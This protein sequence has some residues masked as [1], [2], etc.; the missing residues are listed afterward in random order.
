MK[1]LN[2]WGDAQG[3]R[4][5]VKKRDRLAR[6]RFL[7]RSLIWRVLVSIKHLDDGIVR[8]AELDDA[9]RP[10]SKSSQRMD[11]ECLSGR[12]SAGARARVVI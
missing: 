9:E 7:D 8:L 11:A 5:G 4:G 12:D 6:R 2:G 10:T 1:K 3:S